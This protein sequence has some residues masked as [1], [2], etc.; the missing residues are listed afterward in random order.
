ME[1]KIETLKSAIEISLELIEEYK[2]NLKLTDFLEL[3]V[4]ILETV[5]E[6]IEDVKL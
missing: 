3:N 4:Q 6:E 5:L 1:P 2:G